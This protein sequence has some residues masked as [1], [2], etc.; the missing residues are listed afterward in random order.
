LQSLEDADQQTL[1]EVVALLWQQRRWIMA[2]TLALTI[3][4]L[5][6]AFLATP[7]FRAEVLVQIRQET[8]VGSGLRMLAG[9]FG[10]LAEL[11]GLAA[12]GS[13]DRALALA[14]L[15][16]RALIQAFIDDNRLLPKLYPHLWDAETKGW[17][18]DPSKA[19]TS[20]HAYRAF[21]ENILKVSEDKK[22][23]LVTVAIEW[24]DAAE[25]SAWA[26]EI[27]AR[28]NR[29][30]R[31]AAIKEC[32]RN[33]EYLT[34]QS[35]E[36]GLVALQQSAYSLIETELKKLMLAKVGDEYSLKTID[37]AQPPKRRH[38]PRRTL[39]VALGLATGLALGVFL[40]LA[41]KAY[42][43]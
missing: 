21:T 35:K 32:E 28:T 15:K 19:P 33:L 22:T 20:W 38:W 29:V 39:I 14:T 4:A 25:A 7:K 34:R 5:A 40:V 1:R 17:S 11:A 23:G 27:V 43:R 30:L 2:S 16:S 8:S 9:Q 31:E 24:T 6:F 18:V 41:R 36:T 26:T 13:D 3:A 12:P 42:V 37:P 10:G